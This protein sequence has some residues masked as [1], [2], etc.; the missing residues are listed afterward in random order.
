[1]ARS[2]VLHQ[3]NYLARTAVGFP[4]RPAGAVLLDPARMITLDNLD[5]AMPQTRVFSND[6]LVEPFAGEDVRT[7]RADALE[8]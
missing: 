1:V 6:V 4:T 3:V 8:N 5:G 2:G 7:Q